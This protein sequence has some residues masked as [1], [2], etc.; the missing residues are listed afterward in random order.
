MVKVSKDALTLTQNE[1]EKTDLEKINSFARKELTEDEVFTF[2]VILCDNEVDRDFECFTTESLETLSRLFVGKTG[3]TDHN[4]SSDGQIARIYDAELVVDELKATSYGEKYAYVKAYAYAMKTGGN[5]E[6]IAQIQGGI[7]KEVSV[8]CAVSEKLC[9]ICHQ[10]IGSDGCGHIPGVEYGGVMCFAMLTEPTDAY[11]WS[12][13]AVPAQKGAGVTK[14]FGISG[15]SIKELVEKSGSAEIKAQ[16]NEL[17]A[18]SQLGRQYLMDIRKDVV[19]LGILTDVWD[20]ESLKKT[21]EK[22]DAESL[23]SLKCALE[24]KADEL[25]PPVTQLNPFREKELYTPETEYMV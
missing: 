2:T 6:F 5:E 22:L 1:T 20:G 18:M 8:G 15:S 7:K 11:E 17:E 23:L 19:R 21:V 3:I 16:L 12:F 25:L 4:W 9:S 10:P 13:V 24:K 14:T